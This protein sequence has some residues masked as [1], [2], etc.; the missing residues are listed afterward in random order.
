ME[1]NVECGKD[2]AKQRKYR[3]T[4]NEGEYENEVTKRTKTMY[5]DTIDVQD[6]KY[7]ALGPIFKHEGGDKD[8][9]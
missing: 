5:S 3:A 1:H 9:F 4:C 2:Y 7:C 8:G 6:G